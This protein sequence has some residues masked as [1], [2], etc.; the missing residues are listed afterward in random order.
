LDLRGETPSEYGIYTLD[1][2]FSR[3]VRPLGQKF[4]RYVERFSGYR[5]I[6]PLRGAY[7]YN[8]HVEFTFRYCNYEFRTPPKLESL[9]ELGVVTRNYA[10]YYF[11]V[12]WTE[13][14]WHFH[15]LDLDEIDHVKSILSVLPKTCSY[16]SFP[17]DAE[18]YVQRDLRLAP[19]SVYLQVHPG[20]TPAHSLAEQCNC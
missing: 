6:G 11:P 3:W 7:H 17:V 15:R 5:P 10:E 16:H 19:L 2:D 20:I 14:R 13:F 12:H 9:R 8:G 1:G 4:S 18:L